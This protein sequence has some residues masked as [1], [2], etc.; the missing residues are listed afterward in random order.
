MHIGGGDGVKLHVHFYCVL[1]AKKGVH[2]VCVI[3]G[4]SQSVPLLLTA[5]PRVIQI[6]CSHSLF[7]HIHFLYLHPF[8]SKCAILTP[9]HS[10]E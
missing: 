3:N 9:H 8:L 6:S 2:T 1:H 4:G 10:K 5:F 7:V